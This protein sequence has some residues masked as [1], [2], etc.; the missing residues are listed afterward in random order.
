MA[1][2]PAPRLSPGLRAALGRVLFALLTTAVAVVFS[3]KMYWYVTGYAFFDLLLVGY[4]LP[5]YAFLT[6]IDTARVRGLAPLFLAA[7]VFG[8]LVE[9]V[10]VPIIYE[11][12][13]LGWFNFSYTPL[14]WH[15]PLSI[16]FGWY[17]VRRWLLAG[18]TGAL[19]LGS[20]AVGLF[21]G[22]W[23]LAWRL[24]EN[25]A[26][27]ELLAEGA[28]LGVWPVWEFALHAFLFTGFLALAHVFLG[29]GAWRKAFQPS[30]P[31]I[32]LVAAGL[33]FF[34]VTQVLLVVPWAPLKLGVALSLALI[35]LAIYRRRAAPG[36]LL[37]DLDGRFPPARVLPLLLMPTVAVGIYGLA[38]VAVPSL[39][40]IYILTTIIQV[41]GSAVLGW[42]AFVAAIVLTLWPLRARPDSSASVLSL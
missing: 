37:V 29:Q 2:L 40:V 15:A 18:N 20:A 27:P 33:L 32:I 6:L 24:P 12:G 19:A 38:G 3:E 4:F 25:L 30:R 22:V 10:I 35:P 36:S 11:D 31:E 13:L 21:W 7:A 14:A 42:V 28:R 26:D 16:I 9:G 8:Y 23:S 39:D 34:F 41:M 17:L 5:I 1:A